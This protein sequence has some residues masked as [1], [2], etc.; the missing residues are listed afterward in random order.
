M[1]VIIVVTCSVLEYN[2][3]K[4]LWTEDL[5]QRFIE[6]KN[7][8]ALALM[9]YIQKLSQLFPVNDRLPLIA[10]ALAHNNEAVQQVITILE[11]GQIDNN[12]PYTK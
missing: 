7:Q 3:R 6:I 4:K 10:A 12:T 9:E 2:R 8:D 1:C 5:R 11:Y